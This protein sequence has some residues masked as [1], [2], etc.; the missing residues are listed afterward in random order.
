MAD[1][2]FTDDELSEMGDST[3]TR[4]IDAIVSG[5]NNEAVD[6]ANQMYKEFEYMHDVYVDWTAAF[7][8]YIY[9]ENGIDAL[10]RA[11]RRVVGMPPR[12]SSEKRQGK[13]QPPDPISMFKTQVMYLA[14]VLRGHLQ[15]LKI[16]EDDEKVCITMEPCGSGQRLKECGAYGPPRN[17]SM[18]TEPHPVTWGMTDFPVYCTHAPM[19]EILS[20][21]AL[22]YP[23]TVIFPADDIAS[24]SC[25][26]CIYKNPDT[27]PEAVFRRVGKEKQG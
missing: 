12:P 18:I 9:K 19:L 2:V 15:P 16:E 4:L 21:E 6:L 13:K 20:I 7:M 14:G 10:S 3:L 8:D 5:S 17:F 26:Y 25:K 1:R 11:L 22:G 23:G 24:Q 27:I